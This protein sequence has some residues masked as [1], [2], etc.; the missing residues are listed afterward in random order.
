MFDLVISLF[1]FTIVS[2]S[3]TLMRI[4]SLTF[5]FAETAGIGSYVRSL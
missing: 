3:L 1:L 5:I 4:I 2:Y